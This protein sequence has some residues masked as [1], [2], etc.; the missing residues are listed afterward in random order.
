[1]AVFNPRTGALTSP[2]TVATK[3][4]ATSSTSFWENPTAAPKTTPVASSPLMTVSATP[5]AT[6]TPALTPSLPGVTPPRASAWQSPGYVGDAFSNATI[7]QYRKIVEQLAGGTRNAFMSSLSATRDKLQ[8]EITDALVRQGHAV[9]WRDYETVVI[10][11]HTYTLSGASGFKSQ[12][13]PSTTVDAS[14]FPDAD[15][16]DGGAAIG[17]YVGGSGGSGGLSSR[18]VASLMQAFSSYQDP[19]TKALLDFIQ[20]RVGELT[21]ALPTGTFDEFATSARQLASRLQAPWENPYSDDTIA[22]LQRILDEVSGDPYTSAQ[23]TAL[24]AQANDELTRMRDMD[25]RTTLARMAALG[26]GRGSGT[27]AEA[28]RDVESGYQSNRAANERELQVAAIEQ[29]NRNRET[30][31]QVSQILRQIPLED[32]QYADQRAGSA[33]ALLNSIVQGEAARRQ[34]QEA[35]RAMATTLMG[36][37]VQI[38][39]Q[40]LAQALQVLGLSGGTSPSQLVQLLGG[41]SDSAR[42]N[43]NA[44]QQGNA[45][46]WAQIGQIIAGL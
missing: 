35:R 41:L 37:P 40:R 13:A 4:A 45:A 30:A 15:E 14:L 31:A 19:E 18:D 22:T 34:E 6:S 21:G 10:D 33:V 28:I 42:A 2:L 44:A 17:G 25:A 26:H 38:G 29:G 7:D 16:D 3:P 12:A 46:L 1:M 23:W 5:P 39:D 8:R 27:I 32:Q 24:R 11:G 43:S 36:I 9:Q 20:S